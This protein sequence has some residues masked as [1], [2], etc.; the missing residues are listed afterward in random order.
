MLEK[1]ASSK[2]K[3]KANKKHP[4]NRARLP[5]CLS[6]SIRRDVPLTNARVFCV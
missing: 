6:K 4:R 2:L 1:V 3:T 5:I